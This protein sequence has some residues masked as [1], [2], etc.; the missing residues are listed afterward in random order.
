LLFCFLL[1]LLPAVQTNRHRSHH[2]P[3]KV[4]SSPASS[5]LTNWRRGDVPTLTDNAERF[6]RGVAQGT[7]LQLDVVRAWAAI[8]SAWGRGNRPG[9]YDLG[10][11]RAFNFANWNITGSNGDTAFPSLAS[12]ITRHV[13]Q[14]HR[15]SYAGV[16]ASVGK[17]AADQIAAL[18]AS[19]W[20]AGHYG[21]PGGPALLATYRAVT[22]TTPATGESLPP[23]SYTPASSSSDDGF[24][25]IPGA[26][27]DF[28]EGL[29]K[30][31]IS[32]VLL[33]A[34][35]AIAIY[36]ARMIFQ[37]EIE[38]LKDA[39]VGAVAGAELGGPA[40]AVA[41]GTAGA[42]KGSAKRKPKAT[43]GARSYEQMTAMHRAGSRTAGV[44]P[45]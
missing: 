43:K 9:Q 30:L 14:L 41:G 37:P 17:T 28:G 7:G 34:G 8:E 4:D 27:R 10:G 45:A 42:V 15:P 33:G 39:A 40:G 26:I 3:R 20:A 18:A 1:V 19:P 11:P 35:V 31:S 12:S 2:I 16:I 38:A 6:A 21:G 13:W 29:I 23:G 32:V 44:E 25:G 24:L 5:R 22:S 36:G